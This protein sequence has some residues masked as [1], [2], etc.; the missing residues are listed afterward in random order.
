M[1]P[2]RLS[3]SKALASAY[4]SNDLKGLME[5]LGPNGRRLVFSG[6]PVLDRLEQRQG[7]EQT[8]I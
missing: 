1:G 5:I 6:D 4:K 7:F 2:A 8:V 3:K